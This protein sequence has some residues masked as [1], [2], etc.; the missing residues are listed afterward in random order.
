[1]TDRNSDDFADAVTATVL[2]ITR[3]DIS[4]YG[5]V[6]EEAGF[7]GAARAV[8]TVLSR[9]SGLPWW[10]VIAANGRLV[11]GMEAEHAERLRAE[12]IEVMNG[13]VVMRG[14]R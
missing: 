11:P 8:G 5:E 12:G 10:R 4:T 2:S 7:P 9:T 13:A 14:E 6:A 3:G 1:M